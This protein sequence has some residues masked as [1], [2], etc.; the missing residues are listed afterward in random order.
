MRHDPDSCRRCG[1]DLAP[2]GETIRLQMRDLPKIELVVTEYQRLENVSHTTAICLSKPA[3]GN[4][5]ES[6]KPVV[7]PAFA[8]QTP[9]RS[10]ILSR[11]AISYTDP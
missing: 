10:R 7:T 4:G 3:H 2:S 5:A 1:G 8:H 9:S 11:S 6:R